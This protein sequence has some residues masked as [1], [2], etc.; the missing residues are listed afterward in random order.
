MLFR[1]TEAS[2]REPNA[3]PVVYWMH[4]AVRLDENPAL[5]VAQTIAAT[6]HERTAKTAMTVTCFR[7]R[8]ATARWG[9]TTARASPNVPLRSIAGRNAG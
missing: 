1:S 3:G 6:P 5:D 4:H 8:R 7:R 9:S 2:S